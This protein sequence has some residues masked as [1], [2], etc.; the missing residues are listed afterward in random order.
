MWLG[1]KEKEEQREIRSFLRALKLRLCSVMSD[2]VCRVNSP[3][4]WGGRNTHQRYTNTHRPEGR[5]ERAERLYR[6]SR[7]G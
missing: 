1:K 5:E 6:N 2:S 7:E 4:P 3:K